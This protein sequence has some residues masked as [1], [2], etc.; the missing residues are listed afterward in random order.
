MVAKSPGRDGPRIE[1][2]TPQNFSRR[3]MSMTSTG[4]LESGDCVEVF[5]IALFS[6]IAQF[7]TIDFRNGRGLPC[8]PWTPAG[9]SAG[10]RSGGRNARLATS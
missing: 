6:S 9:A 1:A 2:G 5:P 3:G 4:A 7:I 8:D 10:Y